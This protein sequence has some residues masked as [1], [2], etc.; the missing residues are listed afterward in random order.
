MLYGVAGAAKEP[1]A[2]GRHKVFGRHELAI[3]PQTFTIASHL[4]RAVG[5]AFAIERARKLGVD[6]PWPKDAVAVA[7]V[8]D[9]S[10]NHSTAVGALNTACLA[11][12]QGLPI[13]LLVVCEDN[14][15][16]ISVR[17]PSGWVRAAYADRAGLRYF[18]AD[19]SDAAAAYDAALAAAEWVRRHRNPALL[20]LS[21]VRLFGHAGSDVESA[22]R[23]SI[24]VA[25]DLLHDPL[26]GTARL[27]V[28][29]GA[30]T[31]CEVLQ[32]YERLRGE[33]AEVAEGALRSRP[34]ESAAEGSAPGSRRWKTSL[35]RSL[36]RCAS[37][38]TFDR[39]RDAPAPFRCRGV[40][41]SARSR[42]GSGET[43]VIPRRT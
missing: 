20:H 34:L 26:V 38:T 29:C 36:T 12:Y 41:P 19:G 16:G 40:V 7:S 3:I 8:G 30:L 5:V 6:S 17:T 23:T 1:I 11:T 22:C 32:R 18:A 35:P 39:T 15:L 9:A 13:L 27:L 31:P 10:M 37:R 28:E 43:R 24:E 42:T 14:G 21:T 4:P 33:V 2:G 25:A